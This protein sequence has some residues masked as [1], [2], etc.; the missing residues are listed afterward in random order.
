MVWDVLSLA[1]DGAP[2]GQFK[3]SQRFQVSLVPSV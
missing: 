2:A 1:F 3:E